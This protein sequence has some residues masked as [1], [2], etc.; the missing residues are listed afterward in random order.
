M[1]NLIVQGGLSSMFKCELWLGLGLG[2][3]LGALGGMLIMNNCQRVRLKVAD[4][5]D[6]VSDKIEAKKR[7]MVEKKA[8]KE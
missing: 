2:V 4:M 6:M 3:A 8:A 1:Y 7:A 5:Q